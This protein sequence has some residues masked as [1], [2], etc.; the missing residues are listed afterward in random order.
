MTQRPRTSAIALVLVA[1]SA[2][3]RWSTAVSNAADGANAPASPPVH[4]E[5]AHAGH[6]HAAAADMAAPLPFGLAG[7]TRAGQALYRRNCTSCHGERGDGAGPLARSTNPP[8]ADFTSAAA[9]TTLARPHLFD[10]I[11]K[12][13]DGSGMPA[14]EDVLTPQQIADLAEYVFVNFIHPAPEEAE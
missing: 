1:A 14:W 7:N 4:A 10:A 2:A 13:V 8:P 12:G 6:H 11:A 9:R 5:H 3:P